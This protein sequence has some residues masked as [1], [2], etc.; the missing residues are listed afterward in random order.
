M[1]AESEILISVWPEGLG[2]DISFSP[3]CS[4]KKIV[5]DKIFLSKHKVFSGAGCISIVSL[6]V[7]CMAGR[8]FLKWMRCR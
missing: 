7:P 4:Q 8:V 1:E 5:S 3:K 6:V 2:S